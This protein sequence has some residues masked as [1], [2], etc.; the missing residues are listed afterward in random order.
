MLRCSRSWAV[1]SMT[2]TLPPMSLA[3]PES[4][5][6]R[7]MRSLTSRI[8]KSSRSGCGAQHPRHEDHG[9]RL[10]RALGVPD[11]ARA[12]LRR[13]AGA[14][15]L[16]DLAGGAVLLVAADDLD[17]PARIGV[18]E[19]R[20]GAQHVEQGRRR[21]Q[22]LD[23]LLLLALDAQ[24]RR[25]GPV[26]LGPDV[27]PGIEVLVAGGDRA[28]LGLL[29]AGADQQQVRV[30]EPRLALAQARLDGLGAAVAVAQELLEGRVQRVGGVGVADLRLDHHQRDAVHE[31]DDVRD[32]AALHA[33]RRV[34]AELVDGVELVALGVREVDE[35][36]HR[37][38]LAG[39]FVAVDLR[40]EKQRLRRL[41]GLQQRAVGLAEDL[42]AQVVELAVGE[43]GFAVGRQVDRANRVAE[44][45]GEKPLAE[46]RPQARRRIGRDEAW[47]WSM[48][49]QPSAASWSRNGFSTWRYSDICGG[50]LG[51]ACSSTATRT[52]PVRRSCISP[53]LSREAFATAAVG[54][55]CG[56][57]RIDRCVSAACSSGSG[58]AMGNSQCCLVELGPPVR[59][60]EQVQRN[61]TLHS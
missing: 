18:H 47:P 21:E 33:A 11:D 51:S 39:D 31:Q 6:S 9:Q 29:A 41:V 53:P 58:T 2:L 17:A 15:A 5:S 56:S 36:H 4:C 43:P 61:V 8:L 37:V 44:Y 26:A 16:D 30:E 55:D 3:V 22:P 13:L 23:Q 24:R 42:V 38:G 46:A 57:S 25:V 10:A 35:L 28:E 50:L 12:R 19:H 40:L 20:A 27:L 49:F 14:Q 34:D 1:L 48:T 59:P 45:L 32:D 54:L 7:S 52:R 60:G